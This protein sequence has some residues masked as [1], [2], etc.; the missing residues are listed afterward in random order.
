MEKTEKEILAMTWGDKVEI[1]H[2]V[3]WQVKISKS[4][5]ELCFGVVEDAGGKVREIFPPKDFPGSFVHLGYVGYSSFPSSYFVV[6]IELD[7]EKIDVVVS[8]DFNC[9]AFSKSKYKE[10]E[11]WSHLPEY[12]SGDWIDVPKLAEAFVDYIPVVSAEKLRELLVFHGK[13]QNDV[14]NDF[15][16]GVWKDY[17]KWSLSLSRQH[18]TGEIPET[19]GDVVF[20]QWY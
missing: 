1:C 2:I 8:H 5:N 14:A 11:T 3:P 15:D 17:L 10:R 20:N 12:S 9:I 19:I 18:N 4:F 13:N 7:H 6:E 16:F